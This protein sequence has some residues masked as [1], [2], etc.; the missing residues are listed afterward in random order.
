MNKI[1]LIY[2]DE[3]YFIDEKLK[4]LRNKYNN[5][6]FITYDMTD[7]NISVG[8]NNALNKL[9]ALQRRISDM[10]GQVGHDDLKFI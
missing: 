2:G 1:Y 9:I 5:F 6:D 4:D 10:E 7:T 3:E 8:R